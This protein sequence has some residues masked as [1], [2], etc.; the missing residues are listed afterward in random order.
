MGQRSVRSSRAE[1]AIDRARRPS[2]GLS[3]RFL[4][5]LAQRVAHE[6]P[7]LDRRADLALGLLEC[8]GHALAG[9]VN[10]LLVEQTGLL[11]KGLEAGI[12]D[13][14][15]DVSRLALGLEF[16]CQ[17]RALARDHGRV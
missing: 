2:L 12:D 6:S 9:V 10:I 17:H 14:L 1:P 15:D 7:D 16:L 5:A 11:V 13:L 4:D 3:R 8:L